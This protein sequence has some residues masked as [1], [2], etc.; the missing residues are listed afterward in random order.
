MSS[1]GLKYIKLLKKF[2]YLS[3]LYFKKKYGKKLS[4]QLMSSSIQKNTSRSRKKIIEMMYAI[5]AKAKYLSFLPQSLTMAR[6]KNLHPYIDLNAYIL[7]ERYWK[8]TRGNKT[9]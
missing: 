4:K 3:L 1:C 8:N 6:K 7:E 2:I 9:C 5:F